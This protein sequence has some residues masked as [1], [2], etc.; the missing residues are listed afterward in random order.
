MSETDPRITVVCDTREQK[1]WV[2]SPER[3]IVERGTLQT[4]DYTIKGLESRLRIEK[5]TLGDYVG[6]VVGSWLRFVREL[7]RLTFFDVGIIV[8]EADIDDVLQHRYESEAS[9]SSVIG[10]ANAIMLDFGVPTFWWGSRTNCVTMVE[11]FLTL[12][13]K[14]LGGMAA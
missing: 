12:A 6:T 14:K 8:V 1:P 4:G 10:R 9:P 13:S 11:S 2:F 5:K 3:F 7:N